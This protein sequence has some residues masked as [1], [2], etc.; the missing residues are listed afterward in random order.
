MLTVCPYSDTKVVSLSLQKACA[1]MYAKLL[2]LQCVE[3][4][5]VCG[6]VHCEQR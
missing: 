6:T 1:C 3:Q 5:A 2:E 4:K